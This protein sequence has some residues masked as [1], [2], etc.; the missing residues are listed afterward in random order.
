[1]SPLLLQHV[2]VTPS[3]WGNIDAY[4][5]FSLNHNFRMDEKNKWSMQYI[6]ERSGAKLSTDNSV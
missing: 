3:P 2:N 4:C 1:M 5:I 6:Y